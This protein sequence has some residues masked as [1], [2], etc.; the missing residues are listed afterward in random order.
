MARKRPI[1][2]TVGVGDRSENCP[3]GRSAA[4]HLAG[5]EAGGAD[6]QLLGVTRGNGSTNGLDVRVPATIGTPVRVRDRLT[7]AGA[8]GANVA[9]GS[10]SRELLV[11]VKHC[12]VRRLRTRAAQLLVRGNPTRVTALG[13][14][15]QIAT[16]GDGPDCCRNNTRTSSKTF[17][18]VPSSRIRGSTGLSADPAR[19]ARRGR[20][21]TGARSAQT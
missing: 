21:R 5:L 6:V 11:I 13:S 20:R 14:I 19:L 9:D 8:L 3:C 12:L 15:G 18:T 10:H 7:E 1:P 4:D 16:L 17:P 2:D